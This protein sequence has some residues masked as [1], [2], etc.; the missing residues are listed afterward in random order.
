MDEKARET[1][2]DSK[3]GNEVE[4]AAHL[5]A[6]PAQQAPQPRQQ[7]LAKRSLP[8]T[9]G[10]PRRG[11]PLGADAW[12]RAC[13]LGHA[14]T[15]PGDD[16][17]V[18]EAEDEVAAAVAAVTELFGGE[19]RA[20]SPS[21]FPEHLLN[22]LLTVASVRRG[23][24]LLV[25]AAALSPDGAMRLCE[26]LSLAVPKLLGV[27]AECVHCSEAT[28]PSALAAAL[29]EAAHA[30]FVFLSGLHLL[31]ARSLAVL[32]QCLAV[33]R[34]VLKR[35]LSLKPGVCVV[36]L[37]NRCRALPLALLDTFLAEAFVD[38]ITLE[39]VLHYAAASEARRVPLSLDRLQ[40][41]ALAVHVCPAVQQYV[42]DV[43][44][45][46]RQHSLVMQGPS[47][48]CFE[49]VVRAARAHAVLAG[50]SLVRPVDVD[51]VCIGAI[52][53]RVVLK[54]PFTN[55]ARELV[56]MMIVRTLLPPK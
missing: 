13:A 41:A 6:L 21:P 11:S 48:A 28:E 3:S 43:V 39:G 34:V 5:L 52:A 12:F 36:A 26:Q 47:P 56:R 51:E 2:S 49:A 54:P 19:R 4:L 27:G 44:V 14:M 45:A 37:H 15:L 50:Q 20:W 53:H 35:E 18:P 24:H 38:G 7:Q 33:G 22:G 1:R 16:K 31:P 40:L 10:S 42:R 29:T 9:S 8:A 25:D 46:L 55:A 17:T 32:L 30:R 23:A